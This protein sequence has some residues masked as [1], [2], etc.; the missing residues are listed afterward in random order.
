MSRPAGG[1]AVRKFRTS[2]A[3]AGQ[4]LGLWL[5]ARLGE[6]EHAAGERVA[7]GAIY[8]DGRR[9][10]DPARP[11]VAAETITVQLAVAATDP[12]ALWTWRVAFA[13]AEVVCVEK[14][15]GLPVQATRE[16]GGA[17]DEQ[18][19]RKYVGAT[20][21]HRID[22]DTSGLVL[23][24]RNDEAR[25][26]FAAELAIGRITREYLAVVHGT[27]AAATFTLDAPVGPDPRDRRRQ[28]A[29][30]PTG[31]SA[32]TLV[33]VVTAGRVASLL[34]C[35]LDTGRTHQIRVHLADAGHAVLGDPL[36]APPDVR[37]ASPRLALHAARLAWPGGEAESALPDELARLVA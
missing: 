8:V 14:P 18:V 31:R 26:R 2:G 28:A 30:A 11:L 17:L 1:A 29:N 23:F 32:R 25:E 15:A 35:T 6:S 10:R 36:Y 33:A 5:A 16:A 24:A 9:E 34:R 13:D 22:R 27:P 3:D 37:A 20:L 12:H 19:A 7:A 4:P 21:V